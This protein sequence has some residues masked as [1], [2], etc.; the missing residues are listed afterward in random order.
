MNEQTTGLSAGTPETSAPNTTTIPGLGNPADLFYFLNDDAPATGDDGVET[1]ETADS[2]SDTDADD[3]ASD[4]PA[5]GE[6]GDAEDSNPTD[7][8]PSPETEKTRR[9][10]RYMDQHEVKEFDVDGATDEDLTDIVQRANQMARMKEKYDRLK[11]S[12]AQQ[13]DAEKF[14][15]YVQKETRRLMDKENYDASLA[16]S[17]AAASAQMKGMRIFPVTIGEDG[18]VTLSGDYASGKLPFDDDAPAPVPVESKKPAPPPEPARDTF[19][20]DVRRLKA[21]FP[22]MKELPEGVLQLSKESGLS[23]TEAMLVYQSRASKQKAENLAKENIRLRQQLAA[24]TKA[25]VKGVSGGGQQPKPTDD[26]PF[27]KGLNG[28]I[29]IRR[30]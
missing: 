16:S 8:K 28:G 20:E 9:I 18:E 23:L 27:L 2:G 29:R 21:A 19:A 12:F 6:P 14:R 25:P 1:E 5:T 26:D 10:L 4:A 11:A 13:A 22:D 24:A 7:E 3:G 30:K 17:L 15:A